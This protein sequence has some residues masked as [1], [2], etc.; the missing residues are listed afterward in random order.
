ML[1]LLVKKQLSEIF[2]VYFYDA[3]KNKA[4]SKVSTIMFM[5]W[6]AVIMIG[7]LGGIFTMLSRKI[8]CP[9][10]STGYGMDVLCTYG[11]S[12]NFAWY[13]WQCI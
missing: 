6:F 3:K 7:V 4:R 1:K 11:A 9:N 12:C 13:I 10:G 2:R 5:L 8:M